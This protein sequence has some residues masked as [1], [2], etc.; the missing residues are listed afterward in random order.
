MSEPYLGEIRLFGF[1]RVPQGWYACNGQMVSIAENE[2]LFML[3][4]TIYGGDGINTF[5][6]P[7]MQGRVPVHFG[8]APGLSTYVIG[9]RAGSESITLIGQQMPQHTHTMV[10]TTLTAT[11][12]T[13][14]AN[15]EL[16]ALNGDVLY[17]T[18]TSGA[19]AF[20]ASPLSVSAVGGN[21][22][23]ENQM[24]TLTVQYCIAA[25]GVFPSQS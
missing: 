13:P 4:G 7:D 19:S 6:V 17:V 15:L 23:H 3:L 5:A 21:Q 14:A 25:Y 10:A 9:Q 1:T 20:P 2:A 11:A 16:G 18:D 22:P 8:T 12:K 24:P